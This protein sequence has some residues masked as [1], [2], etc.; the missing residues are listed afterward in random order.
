[1]ASIFTGGVELAT[2]VDEVV[3]RINSLQFGNE[4]G[5]GQRKYLLQLSVLKLRLAR[6]RKTVAVL[7]NIKRSLL[8]MKNEELVKPILEGMKDAKL[9]IQRMKDTFDLF[10]TAN[11]HFKGVP[12]D[13]ALFEATKY[14]PEGL[15]DA[16]N[17]CLTDLYALEEN[18]NQNALIDSSHISRFYSRN[19]TDP[20]DQDSRTRNSGREKWTPQSNAEL[21]NL[22]QNLIPSTNDLEVIIQQAH[23]LEHLRALTGEDAKTLLAGNK[24]KR[25]VNYLISVAART[26][27]RLALYLKDQNA[28]MKSERSDTVHMWAEMRDISQNRKLASTKTTS[29]DFPKSTPLTKPKIH[30]PNHLA[31]LYRVLRSIPSENILFSWHEEL[32]ATERIQCFLENVSGSAWSWFPFRAPRRPL[33]NGCIRV[34]WQCVS[35]TCVQSDSQS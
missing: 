20:E 3:A 10:E 21:E 7:L 35:K 31:S 24:S 11:N 1:M 4:Y 18:H 14:M 16:D 28:L 26:D 25:S 29:E 27:W 9:R 6:W 17:S 8:A 15:S 12:N 33:P 13:P 32:S 23:L 2:I 30:I 22:L 34:H 5:D 19:S